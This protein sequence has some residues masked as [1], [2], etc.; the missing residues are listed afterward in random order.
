MIILSEGENI[1]RTTTR[2]RR[3]YK[4]DTTSVMH[5]HIF[6][7]SISVMNLQ[8]IIKSRDGFKWK[9]YFSL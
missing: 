8:F 7:T 1:E 6:I 9:H 5:C 3:F 4:E 2:I